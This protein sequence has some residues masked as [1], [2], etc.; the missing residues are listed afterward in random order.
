MLSTL[1]QVLESGPELFHN[2]AFFGECSTF[3]YHDDGSI[4]SINGCHDDL[5]MAR[6][7]GQEALKSHR[8]GKTMHVYNLLADDDEDETV[9]ENEE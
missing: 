2:A 5:V 1:Q 8:P 9:E 7:I 4:G 6:A 3:V